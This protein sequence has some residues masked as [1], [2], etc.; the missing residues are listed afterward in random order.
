MLTV[1]SLRNVVFEAVERQP[2]GV[3][4][5]RARVE[6]DGRQEATPEGRPVV[7][8][9]EAHDDAGMPLAAPPGCVNDPPDPTVRVVID[10][11]DSP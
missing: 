11:R 5:F 4:V 2:G 6:I 9:I 3:S 1:P 8:T 7:L 10:P